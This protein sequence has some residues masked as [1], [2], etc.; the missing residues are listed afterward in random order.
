MTTIPEKASCVIIGGGI[1]GTS[2]AYHMAE[3]GYEDVILLEREKLS[4]G[5]T[6]HAAG[7]LTRSRASAN[8]IKLAKYSLELYTRL[9]EETGQS[10]GLKLNGS[11]SVTSNLE[12]LEEFH[13]GIAMGR[14]QGITASALRPEEIAEYYPGI[15]TSDLVGGVII[16]DDGQ[17]NPAD[18]NQAMAIGARKKG[19]RLI[20]GITVQNVLIK[21]Q[22]VWGVQTDQGIIETPIAVNC[23]GMW[24]REFG[25]QHG[26][27]I[28]LHACE[29]YYV[30]TEPFAAMTSDLPVLRE[31]DQCAY[32]KEDAGKLL[33]GAFERN[34]RLWGESGIPEDF[35]FDELAGDFEHFSPIL[36]AAMHRFPP[37][38]EAGIK[39]FFCGPE[40]FSADGRYYLGPAP[41]ISGYY[42]GCGFNSIGIQSGGGAAMA[43]SRWIND[44]APPF[45]LWDVDSR[46]SFHFQ[47]TDS[48]IRQRAPESL[49]DL[50]D[51]HWPYKQ[52][53]TARNLRRSPI[54]DLMQQNQ[55]CFGVAAGWER[56]NW[57]AHTGI[58]PEYQ[59]S[60]GKSNWFECAA[61]EHKAVRET[62]ALFDLSSFGK[63][64][65]VGRDALNILQYLSAA[66]IDTAIGQVIYT[67]WL[68][69]HGGIEADLTITRLGSQDFL[70]TTGPTSAN[71]D[72]Y[73]LKNHLPADANAHLID[74][75]AND[76]IL[77]VMGPDSREIL[78]RICSM[79][80]SDAA[81]AFGTSQH[82]TIGA[83]PI[84]AQRI[85]YVGELGWEIFVPSDWA[86][87]VGRLLLETQRITLAG[88]HTLDACRIEKGFRHFGHELSDEDTLVEAGMSFLA[89][90]DKPATPY[91]HFLGYEAFVRQK[92][93]GIPT[94]RMVQF[95][96]KDPDLMLYH[97]EPILLEGTA[98]G[99]LTSGAY[100][101][102]LGCAVGMGY[103]HHADRINA[104]FV[105]T[106]NFSIQ[107]GL[108]THEAKASLKGFYSS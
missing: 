12:R 93:A 99:Y 40:S 92:S 66:N 47:A 13:R 8:L 104:D 42:L 39:T 82:G 3:L 10:I 78:Q 55:A 71:R 22:K 27:S 64:R 103:I 25:A 54:H 6:W 87:Y 51:M 30:V 65:L 57:F 95:C 58:A 107:I 61:I 105:N 38:E 70:I 100:G 77:A 37:L 80:L 53:K 59:H 79:D 97:N 29:H 17:C 23:T 24:A 16:P 28:P 81:F 11:L 44:D 18:L 91:G 72:W 5:T 36:E 85:S 56:P 101:H 108:E 32:Y 94:K 35:C 90:P 88:M 26:V 62:C 21:D 106:G 73:W 89:R 98:I 20:E 34:A 14:L 76:A 31:P 49:G 69:A 7:L 2:M 60:Y 84:R 1:M 48:F 74:V 50:Y 19:A 86:A 43:L 68:N 9:P 67:Q 102:H 63:F 41:D 4:C 52:P 46:R 96:L 33:L 83:A 45:D 75:T 15:N